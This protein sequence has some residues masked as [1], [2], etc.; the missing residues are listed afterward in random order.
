MSSVA[1]AA[2]SLLMNEETIARMFLLEKQ[3]E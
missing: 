1:L 2:L 3:Y